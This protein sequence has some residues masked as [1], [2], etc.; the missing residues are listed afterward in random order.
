ME[1]FKILNEEDIEGNF[2]LVTSVENKFKELMKIKFEELSYSLIKC[3]SPIEQI[4]SLEL[5]NLNL[6]YSCFLNRNIKIL[7]I[8][9]QAQIECRNNKYRVDFLIPV[10]F[11][12]NIYRCFVVECDGH[13][14][15]EKTK[16]QVKKD[17][18][19]Q[20]NIEANGY[21]MIRFS[22]SEI[23][24]DAYTCAMEVF[25]TIYKTYKQIGDDYG[26]KENS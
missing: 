15:H 2:E 1:Q 25:S 24:E 10:I 14:F 11:Y 9:N 12:K 8:E 13:N 7:D 21:R 5:N 4:L 6:K 19:R 18:I 16:E 3:E 23:Y 17:N 20:R 22:G 26:F